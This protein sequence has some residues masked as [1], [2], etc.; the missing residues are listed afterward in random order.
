MLVR[1]ATNLRTKGMPQSKINGN[2]VTNQTHGNNMQNKNK[3]K[4][5]TIYISLMSIIMVSLASASIIV[6]NAAAEE[7]VAL[8]D[9]LLHYNQ[10]AETTTDRD[11]DQTHPRDKTDE[12]MQEKQERIKISQKLDKLYEEAE[13]LSTYNETDPGD[14][15]I[16]ARISEIE[17]EIKAID[18]ENHK[19][20][21]S[22]E[23]ISEMI[24]RQDA[25]ELRLFN[26]THYEY[27]TSIGIDITSR[28]IQIGLN[29]GP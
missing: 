25:F 3:S 21:L 11:I 14:P 29:N 16:H 26:S 13:K 7:S 5:T 10:N 1:S 9:E 2:I 12:R 15:A 6:E 20:D 4:T 18:A 24:T 27:V 17:S 22:E 19:W 23:Q 8:P 28:E